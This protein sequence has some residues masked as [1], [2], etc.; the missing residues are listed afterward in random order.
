MIFIAACFAVQNFLRQ[1]RLAPE[2]DESFR[3]E[4]FWMERS[5][6]HKNQSGKPRHWRRAK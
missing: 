3:V 2:R 5:E 6:P 4:I 1:Q